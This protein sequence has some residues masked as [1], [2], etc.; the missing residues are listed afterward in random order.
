MNKY[1]NL[2]R[3]VVCP[4]KDSMQYIKFA[5]KHVIHRLKLKFS[6]SNNKIFMSPHDIDSTNMNL[7]FNREHPFI[8]KGEGR[9]Q[10]KKN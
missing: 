1:I 2:F 7:H 8:L 5:I 9:A 4:I 10:H 6:F 3:N